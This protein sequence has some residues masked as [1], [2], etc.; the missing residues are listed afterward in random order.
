M[1]RIDTDETGDVWGAI[2]ETF[3]NQLYDGTFDPTCVVF[4][5][6]KNPPNLTIAP[7]DNADNVDRDK[8]EKLDVPFA[9]RYVHGGGHGLHVPETPMV[10]FWYRKPDTTLEAE[11]N[12][13]GRACEAAMESLGLE[14]EYRPIGD[15]EIYVGDDLVKVIAVGGGSAH[16]DDFYSITSGSLIWGVSEDLA[17]LDEVS[18]P[19]PEK[20]EDKDTDKQATRMSP[21]EVL[22]D[23]L[24][25]EVTREEAI[26]ALVDH[27]AEE[28]VGTQKVQEASWTDEE[29]ASI[30]KYRTFFGQDS[31]IERKSASRMAQQASNEHE[32]GIAAYKSRKTLQ[33]SLILDG[34]QIRDVQ[35]TGDLYIRPGATLTEPGAFAHLEDAILGLD[36]S[37]QE[38]IEQA[39]VEAF[40]T[41]HIE[42]PGIEPEHFAQPVIRAANNTQ[43]VTEYLDL[44]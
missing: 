40:E 32:I 5:W 8:V 38:T 37:D 12:R 42:A 31:W 33:A 29:E 26:Q 27:S 2:D 20:F 19:P 36:A 4:H 22:L 44:S 1:R 24:D 14:A 21:V 11:I 9:R 28:L 18:S 13:A 34:G 41:Y 23:D 3:V 17:M 30:E 7:F 10:Q 35:L 15:L 16:F 39:M 43:P 25:V 6:R